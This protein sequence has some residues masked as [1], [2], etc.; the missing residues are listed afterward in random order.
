M[1]VVMGTFGTAGDVMPFVELGRV[2]RARGH[3]VVV[4]T[5]RAHRALVEAHA[6]TAHTPI[7]RYDPVA[8]TSNPAY[9]EPSL[10]P[11]RLWRDIFVPLVPEMFEAV[12]AALTTPADVVLVHPW[13]HGALYA[14]EAARVPVASVAMAPVTWWSADDPGVY[15]H[16]TLPRPLQRWLLRGPVRWLLN[17]VFG[18]GLVAARRALG[19]PP[20]AEPFF[21]L[22]RVSEVSYGLWPRELRGPAAD[23]PRGATICGFL[24][25]ARPA[26][27]LDTRL[28]E[29]LARGSAPIVVGVGSLL[30]P[31]AGDLY[32]VAR[33]VARALGQRAVLVGADPS[34][35][36][37]DVLVV[38]HAPY[39][40]LFPRA[41]A[42][43]HHGGAGTLS[44]ALIAA[45]PA[46]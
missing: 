30:P 10:G 8:L 37:D 13:C 6:L 42:I 27:A 3:D 12:G 44:D 45:R 38:P 36:T 19:L 21:A 25:P 16:H 7:A 15:S 34:L 1:R 22:G 28:E 4:V 5:D 39:F 43:V 35:A 11:Y 17:T 29:F 40:A 14:A 9:A 18:A 33:D 26:T 24:R 20:I 46:V 31:M 32:D 2:L 23:D 41:S